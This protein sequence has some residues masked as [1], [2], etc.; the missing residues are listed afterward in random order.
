MPLGIVYCS[1]T[2]P[3]LLTPETWNESENSDGDN[4]EL[5]ELELDEEDSEFSASRDF[6]LRGGAAGAAVGWR[7]TGA[8]VRSGARGAGP[9]PSP[10][11]NPPS[12]PLESL[13]FPSLIAGGRSGAGRANILDDATPQTRLTSTM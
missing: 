7:S 11:S 12:L 5:G 6:G 1:V 8:T 9:S 3:R 10:I 2:Y 4:D 13:A